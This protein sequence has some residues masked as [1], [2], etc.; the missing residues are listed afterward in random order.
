MTLSHW[1]R[2]IVHGNRHK[3]R[4]IVS[5]QTDRPVII[6]FLRKHTYRHYFHRKGRPQSEKP[7]P[8]PTVTKPSPSS[9]ITVS[10]RPSDKAAVLLL[11]I[12]FTELS[13][14]E[15]PTAVVVVVVVAALDVARV[16]LLLLL[17]W[18]GNVDGFAL[19]CCWMV[20]GTIWNPDGAVL[21]LGVLSGESTTEN[22]CE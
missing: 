16:L 15:F 18:G 17:L 6:W 2:Q 11:M 10:L 7:E 19:A 21:L 5:M 22:E 8:E 3:S 13:F 20:S 9:S 4:V 12:R 14:L 1:D